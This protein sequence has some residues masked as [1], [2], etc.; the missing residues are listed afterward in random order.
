MLR[1]FRSSARSRAAGIVLSIGTAAAFVAA[2]ASPA[3]AAPAINGYNDGLTISRS[4]T[5]V[6]GWTCAPAEPGRILRVD[7]YNGGRWL[8]T[9]LANNPREPQVGAACGGNSGHGYS[10]AV[11]SVCTQ[12]GPVTVDLR[13][14][15]VYSDSPAV[16][17]L[18]TR[19]GPFTFYC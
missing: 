3:S 12:P 16:N 2:A 15:S 5:T 17:R 8:G 19:Q 13:V 4:S 1:N 7:V 14:Y 9:V 6:Y 11:A 10:G 18:L